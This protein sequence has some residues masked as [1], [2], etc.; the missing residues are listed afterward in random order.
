MLNDIRIERWPLDRLLPYAANARTH[1]EAQVA[2]I[3]G[4]I[5]E[6]G[7][8]NPV[9]VDDR[10]V[11][12]AGHGRLLA[13]RRLGLAE[14]PVIR[15]GHLTETQAR[16]FRLADNRIALNGGWD[17]ALLS[18]ELARLVEEGTALDGLGFDA[19]ELN[20]LLNLDDPAPGLVDEDATP[21]PPA[22]P[23]TRPGDLWILGSHRLLCGDATGASDVERLLAGARPHLMV[24][25]PPYG[26]EYDPSWR[27]AAGVAK[28]K[29]TG[30]VANDDRADWR[31]A[32]ALFP[33]DVAYVW[34][35][36]IHA[37]TVAESLIACGFDIRAQIVWS[38]SRFALGRGDYHWQHEPCWYGVRKGAKSHWQGARDQSTLWSIA[39]A[40]GEDAATPH[41]TQKPVEVMRRPIV[42]N[43]AR[44]DV[45]Y[46]P[47]CGS[48]TTLIAAETVGRVCYA[49]ELDPTY[50]DVIVRR[51]EGFTGQ[52]ATRADGTPFSDGT[53]AGA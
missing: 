29:R 43:S 12:I 17:D 6:F 28:T 9:L 41:G 53:D 44:G 45:L 4:S 14:V 40:G 39:P 2:E 8:N 26:V 32:W 24:T 21:E 49:L 47:F 20:R 10:G 25:D 51:W 35:A 1:S 13:A 38:K 30:K 48:G 19:G 34:H 23:V 15:L 31:D 27:N 42:N 37:T 7:F 22:E 36:A 11:L 16:A 50:C 52:R 5:R 46:E 3:A 18:A 33:G